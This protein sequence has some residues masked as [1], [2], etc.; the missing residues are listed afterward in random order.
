VTDA[1]YAYTTTITS[2]KL[3]ADFP[4]VDTSKAGDVRVAS[5]DGSLG[6]VVTVFEGE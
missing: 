3:A 2:Y 4:D 5:A 6:V 1:V